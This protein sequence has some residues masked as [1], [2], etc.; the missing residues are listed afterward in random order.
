M[1]YLTHTPAPPLNA[2]G[3]YLWLLSDAPAHD[4]ERIIASG[5]VELVIN[6]RADEFRIYNTAQPQRHRRFSGAMVSG[7]YAAPFVTDTLQ[8]ASII[9]VHFKPGGAFP[10][11]RLPIDE[12]AD[13]HVDLRELWPGSS[14]SAIDVAE[15]RERLCVAAT[16]SEQFA[17]LEAALA[18]RLVRARAQ[19]PAVAVALAALPATATEA[20]VS[21]REVA[22]RIGLSQRRLIERFSAEVGM[23]PKLFARVR[24]FQRVI[25]LLRDAAASPDW[26]R[27]ALTCN[28]Y[29]QSHL[30]RD[31]R[32]FGG[33]TPGEYLRQ[34]SP[35]VKENHIP[36]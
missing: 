10:F 19:H 25:A 15:L 18:A 16:A 34:G 21:V 3:D 7:A 32:A 13:Q 9:G 6:L 28:Y 20:G 11:F 23:T 24:R 29:D 27:L 22:R 17:L 36:L 35:L 2:F 14:M 8:H 31:F 30:I 4:R 1:R 26:A 5:T 33:V 12:L